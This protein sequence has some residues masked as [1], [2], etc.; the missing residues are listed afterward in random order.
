MHPSVKH[1]FYLY[2]KS[3]KVLVD[4]NGDNVFHI[5]VC[6]MRKTDKSRGNS[7]MDSKNIYLARSKVQDLKLQQYSHHVTHHFKLTFSLSCW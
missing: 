2:S 3:L 1:L 6:C 7:G 4:Q 5:G